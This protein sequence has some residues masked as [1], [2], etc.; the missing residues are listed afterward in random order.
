[1]GL[2]N[3]SSFLVSYVQVPLLGLFL[4]PQGVPAF[5]LAQRLGQMGTL[6]VMQLIHPQLPLFTQELAA[7]QSAAA[8]S[9][10][11]RSVL[12]V[13][14][15]GLG[16]QALFFLVSP[17]LVEWWLGPG[18]YVPNAVLLVMALDYGLMIAAVVWAQFVLAAGSNP[19][20][21]STLL[22][23]VVNVVL[24]SWS[25]PRF[26]LVGA[27]AAS[28]LTGVLINYCYGPR[29]GWALWRTLR[30]QSSGASPREP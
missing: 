5:Y 19:F 13:T 21:W 16:V 30:P 23:G 27:A 15:S 29:K 6:G 1:M 8:R 18:R 24:L 12:W 20:L 2:V 17:V 4:G 11:K 9:R 14:A 26:G 10:L 22:S 3:L 28:L 25:V 7:G